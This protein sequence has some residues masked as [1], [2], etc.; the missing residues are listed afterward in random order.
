MPDDLSCQNLSSWPDEPEGC[1][2]SRP[3][4][5]LAPAL[6]PRK[7]GDRIK[8]NR[9]DATKIIRLFRAGELTPFLRAGG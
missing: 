9:R 7:P 8:T 2:A 6:T 1:F 5:R 3:Y 4:G